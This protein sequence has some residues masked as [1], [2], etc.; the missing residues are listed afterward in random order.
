MQTEQPITSQKDN[1]PLINTAAGTPLI[2]TTSSVNVE[3]MKPSGA[4]PRSDDHDEA[5][6]SNCP[7]AADTKVQEEETNGSPDEKENMS[8]GGSIGKKAFCL[9]DGIFEVGYLYQ[10]L[11]WLLLVSIKL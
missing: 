11:C 1:T 7:P 9:L 5:A 8:L 10:S 3:F 2:P 4:A 6:A